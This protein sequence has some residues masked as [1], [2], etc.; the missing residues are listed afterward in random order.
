MKTE[1]DLLDL[2]AE[3]LGAKNDAALARA[4]D[5]AP[6]IISKIR[7]ARLAVGRSMIIRLHEI[8][9]LPVAEIKAFITHG[10]QV[11]K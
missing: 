1:N 3:K 7:H 6:P 11:V 8:V 2:V 10:P 5:V 9:N 4:L